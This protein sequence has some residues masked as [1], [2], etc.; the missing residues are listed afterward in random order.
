MTLTAAARASFV[1]GDRQT[2][3]VFPLWSVRDNITIGRIGRRF[4]AAAPSAEA[5]ETAAARTWADRL[6]LDAER[7]PAPILSLSGGNQQKAL[8]ARGLIDEAP[9]VLLDDPTSRRRHRRQA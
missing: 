9:I 1:S 3:G 8:M 2:E 5:L 6:D 4:A 7:L